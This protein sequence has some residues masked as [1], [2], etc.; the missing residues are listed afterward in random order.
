MQG[1]KA[2]SNLCACP[3]GQTEDWRRWTDSPR[4]DGK[5]AKKLSVTL[6][7]IIF[8]LM[9]PLVQESIHPDWLQGH[10]AHYRKQ[11]SPNYPLWMKGW[12]SVRMETKRR[13]K[14]ER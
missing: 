14:N 1:E 2:L 7:L 5:D 11:V 3:V 4:E 9:T 10:R 6:N 8:A 13:Q 12:G